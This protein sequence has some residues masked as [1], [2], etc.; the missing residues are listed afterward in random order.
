MQQDTSAAFLQY[1]SQLGMDLKTKIEILD[2]Q[3]FDNSLHIRVKNNNYRVSEKFSTN[4]YVV[5]C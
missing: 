2:K 4:V 1:V 5:P 3:D